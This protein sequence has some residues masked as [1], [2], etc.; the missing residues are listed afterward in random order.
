VV[1]K[2]AGY[3]RESLKKTKLQSTMQIHFLDDTTQPCSKCMCSWLSFWLVLWRK[4]P[5]KTIT[6]EV[7][8]ISMNSAPLVLCLLLLHTAVSRL[9]ENFH[10]QLYWRRIGFIVYLNIRAHK[11]NACGAMRLDSYHLNMMMELF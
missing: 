5:T 8:K 4:L 7:Q 3:W 2:D 1:Y 6:Q 9:S 11:T 10:S